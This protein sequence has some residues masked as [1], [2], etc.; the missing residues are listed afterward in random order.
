MP[1]CMNTTSSTSY[2]FHPKWTSPLWE[3]IK[4]TRKIRHPHVPT[5]RR[6]VG[7]CLH[8]TLWESFVKLRTGSSTS[9]ANSFAPGGKEKVAQTTSTSYVDTYFQSSAPP[10]KTISRLYE[11]EKGCKTNDFVSHPTYNSNQR[12]TQPSPISP[13]R[14]T[15]PGDPSPLPTTP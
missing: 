14:A 8:K 15:E 13:Y 4:R 12:T 2:P 9:H 1:S 3:E 6:D 5:Q 7:D 10:S 11:K